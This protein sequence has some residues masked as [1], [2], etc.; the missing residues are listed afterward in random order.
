MPDVRRIRWQPQAHVG[1]VAGNE[2]TLIERLTRYR[3]FGSCGRC[4]A[5]LGV[6]ERGRR[7]YLDL[8][9]DEPTQLCGACETELVD[10][11]VQLSSELRVIPD[12]R[13]WPGLSPPCHDCRYRAGLEC[14]H[15]RRASLG[16][17]GIR[18]LG[19]VVAVHD[20]VRISPHGEVNCERRV[21]GT[22]PTSCTGKAVR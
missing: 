19:G 22:E 17:P 14:G 9:S 2:P 21:E 4:G 13:A 6:T 20:I 18:L 1:L 11:G 10:A 7:R 15:P 5:R 16:G 12:F 8:E 3:E